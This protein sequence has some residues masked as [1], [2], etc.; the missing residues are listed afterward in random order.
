WTELEGAP[1]TA[2]RWLAED[3]QRG[4]L[5][6]TDEASV[7]VWRACQIAGVR[8]AAAADVD[9][10]A[11]AVRRLGMNLLVVEAPGK[12]I[13]WLRQLGATFRRAGTPVA[14][15]PDVMTTD[16]RKEACRCESPR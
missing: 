2:A 7:A 12:A 11:R 9:A 8:A 16:A 14:L 13:S 4:A 6:V 10:V 5:V 1:G 15:R 3:P